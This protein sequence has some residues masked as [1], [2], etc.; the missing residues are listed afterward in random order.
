MDQSPSRRRIL[1]DPIVR[2]QPSG[3][4][5]DILGSERGEDP[6]WQ[7]ILA[8]LPIYVSTMYIEY[9]SLAYGS[10]ARARTT[11]QRLARRWDGAV[12]PD[13]RKK[14]QVAV[15]LA[16][17]TSPTE[18]NL[19]EPKIGLGVQRPVLVLAGK[20]GCMGSGGD[21]RRIVGR[22]RAA[23]EINLEA[24]ALCSGCE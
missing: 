9:A 10:L 3:R 1:R 24:P 19:G 2:R 20:K 11:T 14:D 6:N 17:P 15:V 4:E 13:P 18:G 22:K 7:I 5:A 21:H 23:W 12:S 8:L 16:T